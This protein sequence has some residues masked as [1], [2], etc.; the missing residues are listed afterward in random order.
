[1]F[2]PQAMSEVELIIPSRDLV[3]VT[4]VLSGQGIFHQAD[5]SYMTAKNE[6]NP[7]G[8][9]QEKASAY[10]ALERRILAI[11]ATL[12]M[13]EGKPAK[14]EFDQFADAEKIRPTVE[15]IEKEVKHT[16]EQ[17]NAQNKKV[18]QLEGIIRQ[19]EPVN[20]IDLDVS[21]LRN[22]RYLFSMLGLIPAANIERLQTSLERIPNVFFTLREG[23]HQSVVWLTGSQNNADILQRAARSAYLNPLVL[24]EEYKGTPKA[25]IQALKKEMEDTQNNLKET[26]EVIVGHHDTYIKQLQ[27]LIW[28]VRTSR[29]LADAIM[30]FGQLRYTYL[31]VGWVPKKYLDSFVQRVKAVS[32]E[33]I[34][35]AYP[36]KRGGDNQAVPVALDNPRVMGPFQGLVT[37]YGRPLY[38]EIDPT[39]LITIM[40]PLLYGAMFGD[41]GQGLVLAAIGWL[42]MSRKV[43]ALKSMAGLGGVILACG[44]VAAFFG[45]LYG[46]FFGFDTVIPALWM[47]P[48]ENIMSI[49]K[50]SIGFGVILLNIALFLGIYNAYVARNWGRFFF[51][52]TGVAGILLYWG[53]LGMVVSVGGSFLGVSI[54][55]PSTIFLVMLVVGGLVVATSEV[56]IRLVEG[57]RPLIEGGIATYGIQA[58]F[59]LFESFVSYL[60]NSLSFVRVGAFA[61]AHGGLS[62]AFFVLAAM[63]GGTHS[64]GYWI[65]LIIGNIFITGFEGLIV[66]IQTMRLSYYEMFSKFFT[67]GGTRYEPLALYPSKEN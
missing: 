57:H 62:S 23:S 54:P 42:L 63:A 8:G 56:W 32:K 24:P 9:W 25:I 38:G 35:E 65:V 36:T 66:G 30:R 17:M 37:T 31:I 43:K 48:L 10:A 58:F 22:S 14:K 19:L 28:D 21:A 11:M 61:V 41:L 12:S 64:V 60:S 26:R 16:S 39:L 33:A 67:G 3:E 29:M 44:L 46:S 27:S 1:M 51:A 45:A 2:Y 5:S 53:L 4:R 34:I 59:E 15:E 47:H 18:E 40:F 7:A 49:L 50:V 52:N 20:D 13:D 6:S 55:L